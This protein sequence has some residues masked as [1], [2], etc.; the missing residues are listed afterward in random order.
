MRLNSSVI[1]SNMT[2]KFSSESLCSEDLGPSP[3]PGYSLLHPF[4]PFLCT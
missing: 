2:E 3:R 4:L 1:L